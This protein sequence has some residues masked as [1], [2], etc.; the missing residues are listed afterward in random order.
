MTPKAFHDLL[1]SCNATIISC[2]SCINPAE[3]CSKSDASDGSCEDFIKRARECA[4]TS[5]HCIKACDTMSAQFKLEDHPEHKEALDACVKQLGETIRLLNK[6]INSCTIDQG[7]SL[8]CKEAKQSCND[9]IKA[10]DE[11]I[12]SCE[13]HEVY[14]QNI[15]KY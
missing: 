1:D 13:K 14:Y 4:E 9:A 6:T 5:E 10:V 3:L 7:C 2:Q 11:C 12:E 15:K 8:G